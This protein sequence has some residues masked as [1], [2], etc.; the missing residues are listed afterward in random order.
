MSACLLGAKVRYHGGDAAV[1]DP[2]LRRWER[3]G[4]LVPVCPE[5]EGG[6][7]TPRPPA[8][9]AG[10]DGHGVIARVAVVRTGDGADVT[11]AFRLGADA[12]L[13]LAR[14][15]DIKMAVLKDASPSCGST[16]VYDGSFSGSRRKGVGVTTALLEENGVRVFS[17]QTTAAAAEY[18]RELERTS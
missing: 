7:P 17:E 3:E 6:L 13:D 16:S 11:S 9:L 1:D 10:G 8:E 15:Y 5:Q 4:R 14:R 2:L 18:L 12:A